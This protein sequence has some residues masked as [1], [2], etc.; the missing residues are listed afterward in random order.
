[1]TRPQPTSTSSPQ[2]PTVSR[3][4]V[5]GVTSCLSRLD[6]LLPRTLASLTTAGFDRPHLFLDGV[7]P[8]DASGFVR[9]GHPVTLRWPAVRTAGN[10][11]LSLYELYYRDPTADLYAVFQDDLVCVGGLRAYLETAALPDRGYLNLYT[12]PRNHPDALRERGYPCDVPETHTGFYPSNQRGRGAV[13]LVF[14]RAGVQ[15]LL[16]QPHLVTRPERRSGERPDEWWPHRTI[17]G[18]VI[19]AMT[20]AGW[21]EYVHLP[22]LVQHT[23]RGSS[24]GNVPQPDAPSFPGE[25]FDARALLGGTISAASNV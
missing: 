20:Q 24:M 2:K 9:N 7:G 18:G 3:R 6:T 25:G 16:S 5:Y 1:M 11:V 8:D 22:S 21:R 4:V 19:E 10:W 15:T 14:P 17:D 13:A 12:V 23:G